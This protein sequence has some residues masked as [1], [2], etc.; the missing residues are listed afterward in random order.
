MGAGWCIAR[1]ADP[2][3]HAPILCD[4]NVL[5]GPRNVRIG[6]NSA[7]SLICNLREV[8]PYWR[9][10]VLSID[11]DGE[12]EFDFS[13]E[14]EVHRQ[15]QTIKEVEKR[16]DRFLQTFSNT[17]GRPQHVSVLLGVADLW[18]TLFHDTASADV[19]FLT[20]GGK[21]IRAHS[22]VLRAASPVLSAM[23]QS[24]TWSEGRGK[25]IRTE[26]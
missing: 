22:L 9:D 19:V 21:E 26:D 24:E 17:Q 13:D 20:K 12:F 6:G 10:E 16:L 7:L 14:D 25:P 2:E 15:L 3:A 11:S 5:M 1:G 23:L 8:I 4:W 18:E